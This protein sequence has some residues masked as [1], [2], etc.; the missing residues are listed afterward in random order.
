MNVLRKMSNYCWWEMT[1]MEQALVKLK[2]NLLRVPYHQKYFECSIAGPRSKNAQGDSLGWK[3]AYSLMWNRNKPTCWNL[4]KCLP[5]VLLV[6]CFGLTEFSKHENTKLLFSP[7]SI[8]TSFL[9]S[10]DQWFEYHCTVPY[11]ERQHNDF[12]KITAMWFPE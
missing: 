7:N 3:K 4:Q 6:W 8:F 2:F 5:V 11:K 12:L 9:H 1:Q 10:T